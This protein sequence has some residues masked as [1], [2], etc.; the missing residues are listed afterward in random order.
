[1]TLFKGQKILTISFSHFF[2]ADCFT[3]F[4][5]IFLLLFSAI[6]LL[7]FSSFF[8]PNF[9]Q[10]ARLRCDKCRIRTVLLVAAISPKVVL[11]VNFPKVYFSM[12]YICKVSPPSFTSL[13]HFQATPILK[14]KSFDQATF[15]ILSGNSQLQLVEGLLGCKEHS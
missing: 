13:F 14:M 12:V 8:L 10:F 15:E 7:I 11:L 1:M 9:H 5:L 2:L 6:F 4:L 3:N